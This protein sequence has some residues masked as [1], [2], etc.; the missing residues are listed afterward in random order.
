MRLV[1]GLFVWCE[2]DRC[3]RRRGRAR[4][5]DAP[6]A[7]ILG[8]A[9]GQD[10]VQRAAPRIEERHH[11]IIQQFGRRDRRLAI[12]RVGERHLAVGVNEGLLHVADIGGV[13]RTTIAWALALELGVRLLL[14]LAFSNATS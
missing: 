9:V 10:P 12:I 2:S 5:R 1:C 8:A 4:I 7:A 14:G 13:L 6:D 11:A 3:P